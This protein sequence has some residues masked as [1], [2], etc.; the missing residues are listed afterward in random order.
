MRVSVFSLAKQPL[1]NTDITYANSSVVQRKRQQ[2]GVT[3][4]LAISFATSSVYFAI[5]E[6][7]EDNGNVWFMIERKIFRK[8]QRFG[9]TKLL[10]ISFAT[11]SVLV[12][13]RCCRKFIIVDNVLR[14]M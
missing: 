11:S 5:A 4:L 2:I 13:T 10:V 8:R 1:N 3:K 6:Q 7:P 9:V 14:K 12:A